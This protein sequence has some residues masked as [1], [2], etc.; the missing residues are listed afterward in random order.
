MLLPVLFP[1]SFWENGFAD[2]FLAYAIGHIEKYRK[3]YQ[4]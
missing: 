1:I 3:P 2:L 4:C